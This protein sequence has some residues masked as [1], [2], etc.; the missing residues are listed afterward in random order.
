MCGL[1]HS[2]GPAFGGRGTGQKQVQYPYVAV[3]SWVVN[4]GAKIWGRW[5]HATLVMRCP[6]YPLLRSRHIIKWNHELSDFSQP[7]PLNFPSLQS[8]Q[9][10]TASQEKLFLWKIQIQALWWESEGVRSSHS[11]EG[12]PSFPNKRAL[13]AAGKCGKALFGRLHRRFLS[14]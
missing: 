12:L 8:T 7:P 4:G 11:N 10:N 6:D 13:F 3:H 2:H 5:C 1:G 14:L 9:C